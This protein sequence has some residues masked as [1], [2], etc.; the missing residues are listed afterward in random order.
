MDSL[1]RKHPWD[2]GGNRL[3]GLSKAAQLRW[4]E[5]TPENRAAERSPEPAAAPITLT[6]A[7]VGTVLLPVGEG[8]LKGWKDAVH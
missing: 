5:Q 3:K 2:G 1:R 6:S 8:K 7:Y 4:T